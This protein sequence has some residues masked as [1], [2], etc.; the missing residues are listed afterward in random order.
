M[1][2]GQ[3]RAYVGFEEEFHAALAGRI[4]Q[5]GI[6]LKVR[7][8]RHFV[9]R[10]HIDIVREQFLVAGRHLFIGRTVHEDRVEDIHG[11]DFPHHLGY[12]TL[13]ALFHGF[14]VVRGVYSLATEGRVRASADAHQVEF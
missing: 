11:Q 12:A 9:G 14:P 5:T 3:A 13:S 7:G 2:D 8:S 6:F 4:F 1:D 10:H